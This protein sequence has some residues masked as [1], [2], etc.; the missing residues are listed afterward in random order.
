LG[1]DEVSWSYISLLLLL[2]MKVMMVLYTRHNKNEV[3]LQLAYEISFVCVPAGSVIVDFGCGSGALSLPLASLFPDHIFVCVDYKQESI[4]LLNQRAQTANLSNVMTW[5]GRIEDYL[6]PFD[7]CVALHACGKATDLALLQA[8]K[9]SAAYIVSPCCVGKLQFSIPF[10]S[11]HDVQQGSRK[12]RIL[13]PNTENSEESKDSQ[14]I[15]GCSGTEN[16]SYDSVSSQYHHNCLKNAVPVHLSVKKPVDAQQL[17]DSTS[18][19]EF[20]ALGL[21][22]IGDKKVGMDC[23]MLEG[24]NSSRLNDQ[25]SSCPLEVTVTY[26]R[27]NWLCSVLSFDDFMSLVRMADWSS[28]DYDSCDSVLHTI[29]KVIVELDRNEALQ[30][31]GYLTRLICLSDQKAGVIGVAHVLVGRPIVGT[32]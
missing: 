8:L 30:E 7:V 12:I 21:G 19:I 25:K 31:H 23:L 32:Q 29:C 2:L 16:G 14:S 4:R 20:A 9:Y 15:V 28:Y 5:H 1:A 10:S 24:F 17:R 22:K 13:R 27:S 11:S 26:P 18:D 6:E 3:D